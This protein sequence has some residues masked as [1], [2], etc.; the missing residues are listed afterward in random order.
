VRGL[1]SV[2]SWRGATGCGRS[3][4]HPNAIR[5]ASG[6]GN[7]ERLLT[8][9]QQVV[10]EALDKELPKAVVNDF[11][12]E[13]RQHGRSE[14]RQYVVV[15]RTDGIRDRQLWPNLTTVGMCYSEREMDGKTTVEGRYFIG[16]RKLSAERYAEVLRDHWGIENSLHWQLDVSFDED[17]SRIHRRNGAENFA[18]L[19]RMAVSLLKQHPSK[20]SIAC[21]RKAAILDTAFLEEILAGASKLA[22]G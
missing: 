19:R 6:K 21:K 12:V 16:S 3:S 10:G 9:I 22:N 14:K 18:V 8:D 20:R 15:H 7:Q 13:Q 11:E 2:H 5:S 4:N 17:G 1:I